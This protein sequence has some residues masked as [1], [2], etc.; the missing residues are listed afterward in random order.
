MIFIDTHIDNDK[1]IF[2]VGKS[3]YDET[4]SNIKQE[5]YNYFLLEKFS[6][7]DYS[8]LKI[9]F[10]LVEVPSVKSVVLENNLKLFGFYFDKED[11]KKSGI[12][13]ISINLEM[14]S[15]IKKENLDLPIEVYT[16]MLG[17]DKVEKRKAAHLFNFNIDHLLLDKEKNIYLLAE[18]FYIV[19]VPSG[20]QMGVSTRVTRY[21]D[22]I[23][24]KFNRNGKLEWGKNIL[25]RD[26]RPSYN[27]F[28]KN[29]NLHVILNS[30]ENLQTLKDKRT[31]V[32]KELFE[33][34]ALYDFSFSNVGLE[35]ITKI[36]NNR[37]NT[38]YLPNYGTFTN[39]KFIMISD[40]RKKR[41]FMSLE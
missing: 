23:I 14:L 29:S 7:T 25:K 12:S 10:D 37:N 6:E 30:G 34:S 20:I 28:L 1:N 2:I 3:F 17:P 15:F 27:A 18:E 16:D 24:L 32:E 13:A 38:Y 31:K 33:Y 41:K 5:G 19:D 40:S 4:K 26:N 8:N 22:I 35:H 11:H 9:D 39:N 21:D 36:Q